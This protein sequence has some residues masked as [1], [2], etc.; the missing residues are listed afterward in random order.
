MLFVLLS[1]SVA[2]PQ[3][4]AVEL[5]PG[6]P[7]LRGLTAACIIS[8][9]AWILIGPD[10]RAGVGG[11]GVTIGDWV[12]F[13]DA[14]KKWKWGGKWMWWCEVGGLWGDVWLRGASRKE[15][16]GGQGGGRKCAFR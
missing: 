3:S 16:Q 4:E 11:G 5:S 15:E 9:F 12:C 6:G 13:R 2:Q 7:H 14:H 1:G 10:Q 8:P